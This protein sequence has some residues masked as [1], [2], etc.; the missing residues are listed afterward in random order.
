MTIL[1]ESF[2]NRV[3]ASL[4]TAMSLNSKDGATLKSIFV[5]DSVR[6]FIETAIRLT[7]NNL[8]PLNFLKI[9]L[10]KK[11]ISEKDLY[12]STNHVIQF[13]RSAQIIKEIQT[14]FQASYHVIMPN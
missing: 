14:I 3:G 2:P 4:Y 8:Q 11:I 6:G 13:L 10:W 12:N 7:K 5:Q 1:G 9:L